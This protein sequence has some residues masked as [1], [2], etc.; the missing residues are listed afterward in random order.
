MVV[1]ETTSTP[2][3]PTR[4][5][6]CRNCIELGPIRFTAPEDMEWKPVWTLMKKS[7]QPSASS[8]PSNK[9]F[10]ELKS[11]QKREEK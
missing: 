3:Q 9:T 5:C 2:V 11:N 4:E 6:D 1:A 10:Y 7:T 8:T